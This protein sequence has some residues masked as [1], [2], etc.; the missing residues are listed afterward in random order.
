MRKQNGD[1]YKETVIKTFWNVTAKML[2]EKY[3]EFNRNIDPFTSIEFKELRN[4]KNVKR[5]QLQSLPNKRKQS[6]IWH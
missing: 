4:S 3:N 5:K 1:D 2:M 6:S